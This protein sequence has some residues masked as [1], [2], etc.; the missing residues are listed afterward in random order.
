ML[1]KISAALLVGFILT[2][3]TVQAYDLPK[4]KPDKK[5]TAKAKQT[6]KTKTGKDFTLKGDWKDADS[7]EQKMRELLDGKELAT[8]DPARVPGD[9]N[10]VFVAFYNDI[11]FFL[12]RYSIKIRETADG[13]KVWEQKIF[14]IS[15]KLTPTNATATHQKFCFADGKFFNALKVNAKD[16]D[17]YDLAKVENEAD[18]IFLQACFK[19]GYRFAFGEDVPIN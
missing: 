19:V 9:K 15:K 7:F 8:D 10:Y 3:G 18:K 11:P 14:P 5:V 13:T 12:D 4:F 6:D 2:G 17:K 1:K 16:N